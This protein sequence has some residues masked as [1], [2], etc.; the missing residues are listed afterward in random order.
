MLYARLKTIHTAVLNQQ[1]AAGEQQQGHG[2]MVCAASFGRRAARPMNAAPLAGGYAVGE[3]VFFTGKTQRLGAAEVTVHTYQEGKVT[4]PA[5]REGQK[6]RRV[7][8]ALA[9]GEVLECLLTSLCK[10]DPW[11]P[12]AQPTSDDE[13]PVVEEKTCRLCWGDEA[14]GRLVQPCA[15]R[16]SAKWI[17]EHC[18]EQ[19]RR[20]SP[21]Q[22]AAYR[23]GQ[24]M[25]EYRDAL[26]LE[27]LSARLQAERTDG[28]DKSFTLCTLAMELKA[29][30]KFDEAEP[31]YRE[32][33]EVS[34][35][36]L[37]NR[38]PDTLGSINNLGALLLD[39][40]ELATAEALLRE[41]LEVS[42]ETLGS[43]HPSTL[44]YINNLGQ[45]L[46][47]KGDLAAAEPLCREA[48][49]G[50]RETL[51][52]RHPNTLTSI[53][54]LGHLLHVKG[55]LAAAEPLYREA[56]EVQR[57]TLGNRHPSTRRSIKNL[58]RLLQAKDK[59][60]P[61]DKFYGSAWRWLRGARRSKALGIQAR[62]APP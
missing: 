55:D 15:C 50:R 2:G 10:T 33:L 8:V 24:C 22:D 20:T 45:L 49:E 34:R 21:K 4:R 26:S 51:G 43:R 56:L 11:D 1:Q 28:R 31:L 18:L 60:R 5:A 37:G 46:H 25:D 39:K 16:G 13:T 40:G 32:A 54:N 29:Q 19:W 14:D 58:S 44:L 35:A 42:R 27:L 62:V 47:V 38:H 52:D 6:N 9:T 61:A 53:H 17:H 30:G 41:A 59:L 7:C 48:L 3:T 12:T 57:E 23:C 36:T